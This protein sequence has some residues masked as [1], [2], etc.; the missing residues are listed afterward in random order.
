M[1]LKRASSLG[2]VAPNCT[3]HW[4]SCNAML[5]QV[6]FAAQ[7]NV[8]AFLSRSFLFER[9]RREQH[10]PIRYDKARAE[11]YQKSAHLHCLYGKPILNIGRL[12][13]NKTYAYACSKV[14]DLRQYT[15][16]SRWGPFRNDGSNKVDWEKVE[17]ILV[18][19]SYNLHTKRLMTG[20][21]K[22]VWDNPFAGSWAGSFANVVTGPPKAPPSSLELQDPYGVTGTWYRVCTPCFAISMC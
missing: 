9:A 2:D 3:T 6:L 16:N 13:S 21:F 14:Y 10:Q 4:A 1:L 8:D 18:T 5:L 17:A 7:S 12:R 15:T 11:E 19:L 22:E 20:D